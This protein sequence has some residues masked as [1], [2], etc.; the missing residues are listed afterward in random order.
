M[1]CVCVVSFQFRSFRFFSN[2]LG[3][4]V[5]YGRI[6]NKFLLCFAFDQF[7]WADGLQRESFFFIIP[8]YNLV[9]FKTTR[10]SK[11][12]SLQ[13]FPLVHSFRGSFSNS[14]DNLLRLALRPR[15]TRTI[16]FVCAG[17]SGLP[18]L[19]I[20]WKIFSF[21][22]RSGLNLFNDLLFLTLYTVFVSVLPLFSP[23]LAFFFFYHRPWSLGDRLPS[24]HSHRRLAKQ[25]S[26]F[27]FV[28]KCPKVFCF[29]FGH[30]RIVWPFSVFIL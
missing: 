13:P 19:P 28:N 1:P 7:D 9:V 21:S 8:A 23:P 14:F 17:L 16:C 12:S 2:A 4:A 29:K 15:H 6:K 27:S 24:R 25:R 30:F 11:P 10:C 18:F 22:L 3:K 20:W 26:G 5:D